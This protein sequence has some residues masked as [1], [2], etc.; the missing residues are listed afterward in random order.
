MGRAAHDADGKRASEF[1]QDG[2]LLGSELQKTLDDLF[3]MSE[4]DTGPT[5]DE[6]YGSTEKHHVGDRWNINLDKA[7]QIFQKNGAGQGI[8]IPDLLK[9]S[10]QSV[11]LQRRKVGEVDC[12]EVG[13]TLS[14]RDPN[15]N[16][17]GGLGGLQI[18]GNTERQIISATKACLPIDP[19]LQER[20][21]DSYRRERETMRPIDPE[22]PDPTEVLTVDS[23]YHTELEPLPPNP[24]PETPAPAA[25]EKPAAPVGEKGP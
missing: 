22:S 13:Y 10:G 15:L 17:F 23:N 8:F 5:Q 19:T 11:V 25:P 14:C 9:I 18:A 20:G 2:L 1:R 3:G 21:Y 12:L 4:A 24:N 6:I 16:A 7:K